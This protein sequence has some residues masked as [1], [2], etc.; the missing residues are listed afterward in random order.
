MK[1]TKP[2]KLGLCPIGKFVFS[3]EDALR[4]KAVLIDWLDV[5]AIDYVTIDDAIPDGVVRDQAHVEPVVRCLRDKG[6]DA[7][8]IPHCNFGTE[9]AAGMIAHKLGVPTLLWGPRDGAPEPDGTRLRDSLCGTLATSK[10]LYTLRV[11]F[12]Y[13][14]NC[15]IE[16][17]AFA[18]G[19]DRFIRAARVA[20]TVRTMRIGMV[21]Q[22]IDFFWSTI[23]SE[24]DLL[25]W[26]GIE[27]LP[28]DLT[29][30]IREVKQ[31]TIARRKQYEAELAEL[32]QWISFHG[33]EDEGTIL[34]NF[35]FR[36][37]LL[38]LAKQHDLDGFT[39]QTFTSIG[40]ELGTFTSLGVAMLNDLG[41]PIG[42]ESDVHGAISS[43]IAEAASDNDDPSFL[44]DITTRHPDN[45]EAFLVWHAEA[46]LSLRDPQS[47]VRVDVPWILKGLEPG[48]VHFK[49]KDG[50]LTLARFDGDSGG[51]KLGAGQ[52]VTVPGP[53]TQEFYSWMQVDDW[54]RWE[55][56]LVEGPY[57]H[58]ASFVYGHCADALAEAGRYIPGLDFERFDSTT[59]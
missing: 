2:V 17:D 12:S 48:L 29:D 26:F 1:R 14:P 5:Q 21:G 56:R 38:V 4:Y 34:H 55:R 27:V 6:I 11:P 49:L 19:F 13:I 33:Y 39:V 36:D 22:R 47:P 57:I 25:Q 37:H 45:D 30:V 20:K 52:G 35:A 10:V 54:A 43:L 24:A 16:D 46:P 18:Q 31:L 42:P 40:K 53:Y 23:I 28:I 44:A 51:Y 41:Y 9:G 32:K 58:H 50:P 3:H 7:L 15:R 8:F 59:D